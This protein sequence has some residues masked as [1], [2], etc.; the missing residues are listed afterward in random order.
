MGYVPDVWTTDWHVKNC[1]DNYTE[2]LNSKQVFLAARKT[3]NG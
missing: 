2:T 1:T 3:M